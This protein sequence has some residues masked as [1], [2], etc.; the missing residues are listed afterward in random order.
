[1]APQCGYNINFTLNC[2]INY[3][4]NFSKYRL[5]ENFFQIPYQMLIRELVEIAESE[6]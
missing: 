1:M 5:G 2:I 4:I 3:F 6:L